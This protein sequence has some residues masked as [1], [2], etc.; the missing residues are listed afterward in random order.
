MNGIKPPRF[1]DKNNLPNG[2]Y[3]EVNPYISVPKS[4]INLLELSR[5]A[6]SIGKEMCDLQASE[7]NKFRL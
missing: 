2:Y 6:K 1:F 3:K 4:N 5:Y 7:I